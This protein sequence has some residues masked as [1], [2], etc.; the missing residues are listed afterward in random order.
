M[1]T[2]NA[3]SGWLRVAAAMLSAGLVLCA[4][5]E[6]TC[7]QAAPPAAAPVWPQRT[8]RL[9]LPL[10]PG[11]GTDITARLFAERLA[12]R[13]GQPVVVENRPGGDSLVAIAA[14][15]GANDDHTLLFAGM[16]TFTAHPYMHDTLPYDRGDIV[17]IAGAANIVLALAVPASLKVNSLGELVD[18]ARAQPGRLNAA[19][20]PG[21]T[22]FIFSGF[23]KSAGI[24][25]AR[26]PYRDFMQGLGDLAEGRIQ[27]TSASL[28]MLAPLVQ[29]GRVKRLAVTSRSRVSI[30]PD[31]PTVAEAGFAVLEL[32]GLVGLYGPRAMPDELR[33]RIAADIGAVA[34]DPAI[35]A[36]L[37]PL[38]QVVS[39]TTPAEYAAAI[40]DQRAKL[41]VIARILGVKAAQ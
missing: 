28:P 22:E 1:L 8:V 14:F 3:C 29:D 33:A 34:A 30:A 20:V 17:P 11:S 10:G 13:W 9:I 6:R 36:R 41:A 16:G 19:A 27:V 15:L 25:I 24:E 7:A 35:A 5:P 31:I 26:V 4:M 21:I 32:E 23:L 12:Q 37:A 38:G 18:L 2:F 40:D 39:A